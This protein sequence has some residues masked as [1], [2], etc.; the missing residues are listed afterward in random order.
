MRAAINWLRAQE[1]GRSAPPTGEGPTPYSTIVK[2]GGLD[3]DW[4][5][6]QAWS[7]VVQKIAAPDEYTWDADVRFL[8]PGA[9]SEVLTPGRTFELYEGH[10]LVA[11]GTLR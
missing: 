10:R 7:L 4:P 6:E 11:K 3:D 8:A 1:G 9:P 5:P 2:L